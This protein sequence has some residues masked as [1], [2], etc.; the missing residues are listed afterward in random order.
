MENLTINTSLNFN[1]YLLLILK[2]RLRSVNFIWDLCWIASL[3]Y[4]PINAY[5]DYLINPIEFNS[6]LK[7]TVITSLILLFYPIYLFFVY[8]KSFQSNDSLLKENILVEFKTNEINFI[9]NFSSNIIDVSKINKIRVFKN[10]IIIDFYQNL[11]AIN[12]KKLTK[13]EDKN[14]LERI[15]L[16]LKENKEIQ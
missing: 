8:K 6:I 13:E 2:L 16:I 7:A 9:T 15:R 4:L 1:E 10:F 11:I 3:I 5:N 12:R 14:V